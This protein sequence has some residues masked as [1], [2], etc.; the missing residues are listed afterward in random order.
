MFDTFSCVRY[1]YA[2]CI[3]YTNYYSEKHKHAHV[4]TWSHCID[5]Q[6]T[7]VSFPHSAAALGQGCVIQTSPVVVSLGGAPQ[8]RCICEVFDLQTYLPYEGECTSL[9]DLYVFVP[10]L[11]LVNAIWMHAL[12]YQNSTFSQC[13]R[14]DSMSKV[15]RC[16]GLL[17]GCSTCWVAFL[18]RQSCMQHDPKA[19]LWSWRA[20]QGFLLP[21]GSTET[22]LSRLLIPVSGMLQCLVHRNHPLIL[23]A[24]K[25]SIAL[26]TSSRNVEDL[27]RVCAN[28]TACQR[29]DSSLRNKHLD[30]CLQF[31]MKDMYLHTRQSCT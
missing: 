25:S 17:R 18:V 10:R 22:P 29:S 12:K 2:L 7:D 6:V 9:L 11:C 14:L 16:N 19:W 8:A 24:G 4:H 31:A 20:W 27:K 26:F 28:E 15:L 3:T 1:K 5:E 13:S 30:Y 23:M 21:P